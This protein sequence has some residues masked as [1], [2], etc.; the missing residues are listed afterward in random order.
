MLISVIIP[1][2]NGQD[3]IT[4]CLD[5][6]Y[7]QLAPQ[8]DF[9]VIIV[10]DVSPNNEGEVLIKQ[11]SETHPNL[12]Y[13]R[14]T[15]NTR[16]GGAR[17]TG[18]KLA[19][20]DFIAFIDQDDTFRAGSWQSVLAAIKR[21]D[22]DILMVTAENI[23]ANGCSSF[24]YEQKNTSEVLSG[25]GFIVKQQI[26]WVP[27]CFIYRREF[28]IEHKHTFTENTRFE[29]V[30]FVIKATI[31]AQRMKFLPITFVQHWISDEQTSTVA[32]NANLIHDLI[33]LSSRIGALTK[34]TDISAEATQVI[35]HQ[36]CFHYNMVVTRFLWRLKYS[37]I[38]S[39]L[40]KYPAI[41]KGSKIMNL[42][43]HNKT[44]ASLAVI[45]RPLLMLIWK[46]KRMIKF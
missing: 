39:L 13:Y 46:F 45:A 42:S 38:I 15:I 9:E 5:S 6:I 2:Y 32:N 29:D 35:K 11:Y 30:D 36:Y 28:L 43:Q 37:Q 24:G 33:Y 26:P 34:T 18:V 31:L 17:N 16:Q 10:D 21:D 19:K 40:Q 7:S 27:W 22:L 12:R 14:H 23:T 20:G 44:Y 3:T 8:D 41:C 4:R 1:F 25:Q